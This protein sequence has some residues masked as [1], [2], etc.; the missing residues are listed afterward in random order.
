MSSRLSGS[1][2]NPG[3][4]PRQTIT[5]KK[6]ADYT[7]DILL[8]NDDIFGFGVFFVENLHLKNALQATDY[9]QLTSNE[10]AA[11]RFY[12]PSTMRHR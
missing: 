9:I 1:P 6:R 5:I 3:K 4:G 8:C 10:S 11:P 12:Y 7:L 2:S